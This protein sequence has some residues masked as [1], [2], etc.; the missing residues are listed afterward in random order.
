MLF[1]KTALF[2]LLLSILTA[3]SIRPVNTYSIVALDE[4]TGELGVAVQSHWFSVGSLVP[5]AKAGVGA[6]ATQSFVKV[7]YG[8]DGLKL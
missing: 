8:P 2:L 6:V 3:Q 5:W 1:K 4:E 7:E